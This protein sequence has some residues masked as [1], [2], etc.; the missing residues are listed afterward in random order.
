MKLQSKTCRYER[1]EI[2]I[3]Y[4]PNFMSNIWWNDSRILTVVFSTQSLRLDLDF[5]W[6]ESRSISLRWY[7][8]N[9][10]RVFVFPSVLHLLDRNL[11]W[12]GIYRS[13]GSNR[14][15]FLHF[16]LR[17]FSFCAKKLYETCKEEKEDISEKLEGIKDEKKNEKAQ[18]KNCMF[19][20]VKK[21]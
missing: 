12:D 21:E 10:F 8:W 11:L 6:D 14:Y 1:Y 17:F 19:S 2:Q 20:C 7:Q 13:W 3:K 5:L 9:I 15:I 18:P 4:E 16:I